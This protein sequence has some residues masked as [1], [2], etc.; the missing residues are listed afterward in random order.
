MPRSVTE[1]NIPLKT[2]SLLRRAAAAGAWCT[3][4]P[5]SDGPR[6]TGTRSIAVTMQA[7]YTRD[8][9]AKLES[10]PMTSV[11]ANFFPLGAV[12]SSAGGRSV[13]RGHCTEEMNPAVKKLK[14]QRN[15]MCS[16]YQA[17]LYPIDQNQSDDLIARARTN[18]TTMGR[19]TQNHCADHSLRLS[20]TSEITSPPS[21]NDVISGKPKLSPSS[22]CSRQTGNGRGN[23]LE[24]KQNRK[25]KFLIR[26][27]DCRGVPLI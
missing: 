10:S 14:I 8:A 26:E 3:L 20:P 19:P 27:G 7:A 4:D 16:S 6:S 11:D 25:T 17:L 1:L 13:Q 22:P 23:V 5:T 9:R 15:A 18:T 12:L 24:L 2:E 21:I